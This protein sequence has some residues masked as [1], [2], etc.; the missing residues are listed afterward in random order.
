MCA[1]PTAPTHS[2]VVL[3]S[4]RQHF[5]SLRNTNRRARRGQD[6]TAHRVGVLDRARP[7]HVGARVADERLDE[8]RI[9]V[10]VGARPAADLGIRRAGR[11]AGRGGVAARALRPGAGDVGQRRRA[12]S[13]AGR[14][15][16]T[17]GTLWALR[18]IGACWSSCTRRPR[19][20][21]CAGG[22]GVALRSG[23]TGI[24][25]RA[26]RTD[27][28]LCALDARARGAAFDVRVAGAEVVGEE[29][30]AEIGGRDLLGAAGGAE[31]AVLGD[32]AADAGGGV[33][34]GVGLL[35]GAAAPQQ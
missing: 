3:T 26:L 23:G 9:A 6:R 18:A 7:D 28:A 15:L 8:D 12:A 35:A 2:H 22:A 1:E 24:A 11:R 21:G 13:G 30:A 31:L 4:A 10:G 16:R 17:L 5:F 34:E 19:R 33:G 27:G 25:L 29:D 20:A 14:T 32:V